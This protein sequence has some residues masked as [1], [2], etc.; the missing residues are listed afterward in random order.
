[1]CVCVCVY[2]THIYTRRT[3]Y[4]HVYII[5]VCIHTYRQ[6]HNYTHTFDNIVKKEQLPPFSR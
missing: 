5:Y 6:T 4:I 1:M 3:C 2:K